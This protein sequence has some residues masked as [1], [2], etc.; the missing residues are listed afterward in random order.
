MRGYAIIKKTGSKTD[1]K[2]S[3]VFK[4]LDELKQCTNEFVQMLNERSNNKWTVLEITQSGYEAYADDDE[5][6]NQ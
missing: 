4:D 6:K 5:A 1:V 3:G 2:I